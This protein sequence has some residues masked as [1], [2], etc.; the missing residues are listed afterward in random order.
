M[1]HPKACTVVG[2]HRLH[3]ILEKEYCSNSLDLRLNT[4]QVVSIA[5]KIQEELY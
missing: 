2:L 3:L 5:V 4:S 1:L